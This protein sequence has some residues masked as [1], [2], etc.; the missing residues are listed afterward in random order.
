MMYAV[1]IHG[2]SPNSLEQ[3][4]QLGIMLVKAHSRE[5]ALVSA[6]KECSRY[7]EAYKS[8]T[9]SG[10]PEY[11][12]QYFTMERIDGYLTRSIQNMFFKVLS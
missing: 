1:E 10:I 4:M 12:H 9:F 5:D 6:I 3:T 11:L 7:V 2:I 8:E